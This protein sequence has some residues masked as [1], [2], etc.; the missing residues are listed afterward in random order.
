MVPGSPQIDRA[1]GVVDPLAVAA[2][3]LAVALHV[4]LLEIGRRSGAGAGR[5]AACAWRARRP[6]SCGTRRRAAPS[7][8][9]Q[10]A[11]ERRGAEMLVHGVGAGEQL[12]EALEA[13]RERDRQA[14]RRPQASSGRRPSPRSRTCWPGRCRTRATASALV[15]TA[16]KCLATAASRRALAAARP[17]AEPALV[18]V[19]WVVKVLEATMN[20]VR[21]GSSPA[22]VS[23]RCAPSTLETKCG[24]RSGRW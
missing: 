16:T 5:R 18:M 3:R 12:L 14:D 23:A 19:S 21:A 13:D 1:G 8:H 20:S 22:R 2:H 7:D 9:R 4:A 15:E 24:R 6:G 10:V 17:R 11:L